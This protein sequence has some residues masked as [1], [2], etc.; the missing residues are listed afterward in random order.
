MRST[1]YLSFLLVLCVLFSI[2]VAFDI[3]PVKYVT[4]P[5]I[6][7]PRLNNGG[8]TTLNIP[9]GGA[10]V[11]PVSALNNSVAQIDINF[12]ITGQACDVGDPLVFYYSIVDDEAQNVLLRFPVDFFNLVQ[13][14]GPD[15]IVNLVNYGT[16]RMNIMFTWDGRKFSN[17]P[18]LDCCWD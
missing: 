5:G 7:R 12:V 6:I 13:C 2:V 1:E 11:Q 15:E 17:E 3:E 9:R 10:I 16:T 8:N 14:C 4:K 18:Q